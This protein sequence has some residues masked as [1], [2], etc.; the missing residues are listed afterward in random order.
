MDDFAEAEPVEVATS[1]SPLGVYSAG[2]RQAQLHQPY[3]R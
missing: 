1:N 3:T 2:I